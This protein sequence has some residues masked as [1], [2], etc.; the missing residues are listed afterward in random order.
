MDP[1]S[2]LLNHCSVTGLAIPKSGIELAACTRRISTYENDCGAS[3]PY[4]Y[5]QVISRNS[6]TTSGVRSQF[7]P[8]FNYIVPLFR[9]VVWVFGNNFSTFPNVDR[10]AVHP[11]NLS[12]GPRSASQ[13]AT[14][15]RCKALGLLRHL[16]TS[17]HGPRSRHFRLDSE[18]SYGPIICQWLTPDC[19]ASLCAA[20]AMPRCSHCMTSMP[21]T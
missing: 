6:A 21:S 12:G 9:V 10:C 3:Y 8:G 11:R 15:P 13:S 18:F 14:Y 5:P 20:Q 19:S 2:D 17:G 7:P 16:T 1:E 4:C